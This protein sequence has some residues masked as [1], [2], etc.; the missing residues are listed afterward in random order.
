MLNLA[1]KV[2]GIIEKNNKSE[3][4]YRMH[5]KGILSQDNFDFIMKHVGIDKKPDGYNLGLNIGRQAGQTV[6]HVHLHLIPRYEFDVENPRGG[7]RHIIP[8]RG[9]Y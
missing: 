4:Y 6:F 5:Q 9:Y 2:K 3:A 8:E 1:D 7:V